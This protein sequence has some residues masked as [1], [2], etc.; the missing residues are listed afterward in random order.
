MPLI[1]AIGAYPDCHEFL[2]A[3]VEDPQ[4]GRIWQGHG[5][6]GENA[7]IK[8][9]H[10]CHQFRRLHRKQNERIY[11]PGDKMHGRSEYDSLKLTVKEDTE[12]GW[13]VY[14]EQ[15]RNP[16]QSIQLL[17]EVEPDHSILDGD[18]E[19]VEHVGQLMIEDHS[20]GD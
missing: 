19:V 7:A 13:W 4:G 8:F 1:N 15:Y 11:P 12:G 9:R 14:A 3:I 20:N 2:E 16:P 17:S 5:K 10:R 18:Y 6:D